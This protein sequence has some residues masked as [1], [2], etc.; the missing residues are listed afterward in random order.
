MWTV[1]VLKM[2]T[3]KVLNMGTVRVLNI[4]TSGYLIWGQ[5]RY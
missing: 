3:V 2:V 5:S 1:T 4:E